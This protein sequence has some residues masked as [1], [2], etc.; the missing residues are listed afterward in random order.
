MNIR[1]SMRQTGMLGMAGACLFIIGLFIEYRFGLF[2]PDGSV[3]YTVDQV[4]FFIGQI[5]L[6]IMLLGLWQAWAAGEGVFG[7]LALGILITAM[8]ALIIAQA[9]SILTSNQDQLL[10]PIGGLLQLI[11]SLLTGIAVVAAKRWEGWQRFTILIQGIYLLL[12]IML[13]LFI[14][15]REPTLLTKSL[16]QVT[17]FLTSL[18]L[19]TQSGR[20]QQANMFAT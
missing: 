19:F 7:K 17:W 18:A 12:V 5:G 3:L 16:W 11:G 9:L 13:P 14:A 8:S 10:Y 15:N 4:I 20:L 1:V 6:L 2:S